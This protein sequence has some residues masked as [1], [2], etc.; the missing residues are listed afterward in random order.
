MLGTS[1]TSLIKNKKQFH[2]GH[3][4]NS[5][6]SEIDSEESE[7]NQIPQSQGESSIKSITG[8]TVFESSVPKCA[9]EETQESEQCLPKSSPRNI[10]TAVHGQSSNSDVEMFLKPLESDPTNL[11]PKAAYL[12]PTSSSRVSF[13]RKVMMKEV[14]RYIPTSSPSQRSHKSNGNHISKKK[15]PSPLGHGISKMNRRDETD[16]HRRGRS[17][18]SIYISEAQSAKT[19]PKPNHPPLTLSKKILSPTILSSSGFSSEVEVCDDVDPRGSPDFNMPVSLSCASTVKSYLPPFRPWTKYSITN[20][21]KKRK[22]ISIPIAFLWERIQLFELEKNCA[23]NVK[24]SK[25]SISSDSIL[26]SEGENVQLLLD[27]KDILIIQ[28]SI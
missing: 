26:I 1:H 9:S 27:K 4:I 8:D 12:K 11:D 20:S 6:Q 17:L 3:H 14:G 16:S 28:V 7:P 10:F 22:N 18:G 13:N 23:I 2:D 19:S 25:L 5:M 21:Q 15:S 24:K